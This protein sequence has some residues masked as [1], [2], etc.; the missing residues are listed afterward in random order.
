M[1]FVARVPGAASQAENIRRALEPIVHPHPLALLVVGEEDVICMPLD[2]VP[3]SDGVPV[4]DR[5][6]AVFVPDGDTNVALAAVHA[7]TTGEAVAA[8]EWM[9]KSPADAETKLS[10]L[11]SVIPLFPRSGW[12]GSSALRVLLTA[13]LEGARDQRVMDITSGSNSGGASSSAAVHGAMSPEFQASMY[14]LDMLRACSERHGALAD[15]FRA[16]AENVLWP[17]FSAHVDE[18]VERCIGEDSEALQVMLSICE[19]KGEAAQL[20]RWEPTAARFSPDPFWD[21]V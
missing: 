14:L 5:H 12:R 1:V 2:G 7:A 11:L 6:R 15:M 18:A 16:V 13:A 8:S 17:K 4:G 3:F 19:W 20:P 9:E 10:A 21:L